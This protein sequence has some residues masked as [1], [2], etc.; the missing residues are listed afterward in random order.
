M[1][2]IAGK[3]LKTKWNLDSCNLAYIILKHNLMVLDLN[4]RNGSAI[5]QINP[6]DFVLEPEKIIEIIQNDVDNLSAKHFWLP[7]IMSLEEGGIFEFY[8]KRLY[9]SN[10]ISLEPIVN[11]PTSPYGVLSKEF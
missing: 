7:Q 4:R 6:V 2:T 11:E 1:E 10:L 8:E 5:S 9:K 3:Q